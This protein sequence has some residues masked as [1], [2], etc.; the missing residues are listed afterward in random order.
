MRLACIYA[1]M[2]ESN[3]VNENHLRA[4]LALWAYTERSVAYVF[5]DRLGDPVADAIMS[6]VK[7]GELT[8]TDIRDLFGRHQSQSRIDQALGLLL[9]AGKVKR[10]SRDTG[11]R[12]A[13]VWITA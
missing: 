11:G 8:R 12:P 3:I 1:V 5:G 10:E 2:D 6:A 7:H 13:E 4:A 9:S